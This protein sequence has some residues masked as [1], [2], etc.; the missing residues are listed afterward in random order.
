MYYLHTKNQVK[1]FEE[2]IRLHK[3]G[4]SARKIS[5]LL[6]V[7]KTTASQW[8]A[9]FA[10]EKGQIMKVTRKEEAVDPDRPRESSEPSAELVR[11]LRG[12]IKELESQLLESRIR[13]EA[14]DEMINVAE[15]MFGIPIRKKAGAKR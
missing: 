8:I 5:R 3:S 11:S 7:D 15:S 9:I 1:Y 10:R 12:R 4:F 13:A 14:Y 6:P 2:V